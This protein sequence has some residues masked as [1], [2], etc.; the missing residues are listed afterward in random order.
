MAGEVDDHPITR[1]RPSGG[2]SG[3]DGAGDHDR[4]L[5]RVA[6]PGYGRSR[7][8]READVA[9]RLLPWN[10]AP[11]VG[12]LLPYNLTV[13]RERGRTVV[14]AMN[15]ESALSLLDSDE[16]EEVAQTVGAALKRVVT[17]VTD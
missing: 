9:P 10:P 13:S 4:G 16:V 15:P 3:G 2:P 17:A 1:Y 5:L 8:I 11:E 14:R 6:V 12:V 7:A